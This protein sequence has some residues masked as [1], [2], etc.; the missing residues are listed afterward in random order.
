MVNPNS[1]PPTLPYGCVRVLTINVLNQALCLILYHLTKTIDIVSFSLPV[2]IAEDSKVDLILGLETIKKLNL[3]KII[4]EFFQN[5]ENI[6]NRKIT[7][8]APS[9]RLNQSTNMVLNHVDVPLLLRAESNT[10]ENKTLHETLPPVISSLEG[11]KPLDANSRWQDNMV[12]RGACTSKTCTISCVC[13]TSLAAAV[14]RLDSDEFTVHPTVEAAIL[15]PPPRQNYLGVTTERSPELATPTPSSKSPAQTRG[16]VA[17]L[18]REREELPEVQPFGP[19]EIDYKSK[20]TF[21]PFQDNPTEDKMYLI[22]LIQ[23]DGTPEQIA[24]IKAI[25]VKHIKLFNNKL[26]SPVW[27]TRTGSRMEII[28]ESRSTPTN[29]NTETNRNP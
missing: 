21:A 12:T 4:P 7:H 8:I 28:Q 20:D 16:L 9:Q 10:V 2:R 5:P 23:I 13:P 17:A 18:L 3:V 27:T 15:L 24:I 14:A 22:D 1:A 6:E 11:I 19:E 26:N 25:C 29:I